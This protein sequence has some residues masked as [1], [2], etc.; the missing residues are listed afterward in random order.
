MHVD[1]PLKPSAVPK[2]PC[3]PI[4]KGCLPHAICAFRHVGLTW[5]LGWL[6]AQVV[7][8]QADWELALPCYYTCE[9]KEHMS[10]FRTTVS[11]TMRV[12]HAKL[13]GC[14]TNKRVA[15]VVEWL[16]RESTVEEREV[17]DARE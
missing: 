16:C 17:H 12:P 13:C 5:R 15:P 10:T 4:R 3:G 7:R 8:G 9:L 14:V 2:M 1:R 6:F 11:G